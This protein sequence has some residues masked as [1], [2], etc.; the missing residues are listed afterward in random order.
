MFLGP[1][2]FAILV[3][4]VLLALGSGSSTPGLIAYTFSAFVLASI[5]LEFVRG[6][7]AAGSLTQLIGRNRRRYG[8]YVVH[9]AIVLLALGVA[10]SSAYGST[11]ERKLS[12]GQSMQVGGYTL[13]YRSLSQQRAA[14]HVAVRAAVDVYRG[15]GFVA[16]VEPGKNRYFAE[17]QVSNE[18]AIH[19]DWLRAEDVD[20]IADQIDPSGAI[21]FKALVKP[22]VNLIWL[23]GIVFFAGALVTLWPDPREQRRLAARY[24]LAEA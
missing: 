18:M 3:G 20:V 1:A 17:Q 14:N 13:T 24:A 2:G 22:L 11:T 5:T 4:V 7:R 10:G 8:G 21:Y 15:G 23:A 9:A 12:P 16:R 6:T 19:T